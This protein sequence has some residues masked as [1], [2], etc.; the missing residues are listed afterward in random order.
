MR[1][2]N[3]KERK[4]KTKHRLSSHAVQSLSMYLAQSCWV[5]RTLCGMPAASVIPARVSF[6]IYA[7]FSNGT[8]LNIY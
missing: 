3:K 8:W 4:T 6:G 7:R 5:F 1:N 2:N